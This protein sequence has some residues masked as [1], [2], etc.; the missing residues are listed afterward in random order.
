MKKEENEFHIHRKTIS[1]LSASLCFLLLSIFYIF[2][3]YHDLSSKME[4]YSFI[5]KSEAEHIA[6]TIDCVMARTNT[7][8][9][10][11]QDH[12]GDTSFFN[13]TAKDIYDSI[14]EETGITPKNFAIA[15]DGVVSDVYP[16]E[17]NERFLGF[18]FLDPDKPG[19]LDAIKAY[20]DKTTRLTNPFELFQGGRGMGGRSPVILRNENETKLWGLVTV[21]ID[22]ENLI[23]ILCLNKL[24]RMGVNYLLSYIDDA[25]E[26]HLI[27][28][29]GQVDSAA[30][31]YRFEVRNLTWELSVSPSKGWISFWRML[32]SIFVILLISAFV[33]IFTSIMLQLREKNLI[34][35]HVSNTDI[36][37]GNLNRRAYENALT[38]LSKEPLA[39]DFVYVSADL[40]GL[41]QINDSKGHLAGDKLIIGAGDCMTKVFGDF[42]KIYRIGG[43]EFVA[44]IHTGQQSLDQLMEKLHTL[45]E[46][47]RLSSL[48]ELSMSVGHASCKEFPNASMKELI[49][50][51][52]ERMYS[53]KNA[54]YQS[55]GLD[56]RRF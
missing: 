31:K 53:A 49:K 40:N 28:S 17:G 8:K 6:T 50:T 46:N 24:N 25:G 43:D 29:N 5:A 54:Y 16:M 19:N 38:E 9:A 42:G 11:I 52:D 37:T 12:N 51:A 7:L 2:Y 34:L 45:A 56:R 22:Y 44:L 55:K 47:W 10:L 30:Q 15:P 14:I 39:E 23:Q 41:K 36:L 32:L 21:T 35:I 3:I 4:R 33:G 1:T 20:K 48:D 13:K 27:H 26:S 18:N